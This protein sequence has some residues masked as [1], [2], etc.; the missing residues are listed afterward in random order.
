[1]ISKPATTKTLLTNQAVTD[2]DGNVIESYHSA[3]EIHEP[4]LGDEAL[5]AIEGWSSRRHRYDFDNWED[6]ENA[7]V[8]KLCRQCLNDVERLVDDLKTTGHTLI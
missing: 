6:K 7:D 1:V 3:N 8:I 4:D 5:Q 2:A